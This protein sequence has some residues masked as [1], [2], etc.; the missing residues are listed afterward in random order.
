[1]LYSM[2]A[3]DFMKI[4]SWNVNG[5]RSVFK[6][7]FLGWLKANQPDIVCLQEIKADSQGLPAEYTQIKG[8]RAYFNSA[9]KKGYAGVAVYTQEK[10]LSVE[11]KLGLKR[12]DQEGRF[13]KLV[14]KN[15][16]LINFYIPHGGRAKENLKYKLEAYAKILKL[17]K[18]LAKKKTILIG[19]FNI[20]HTELDLERP[21]NNKDNIM[22]TPEERKQLDALIGLGYADTFRLRYPDKKAYTW[23]PYWGGLRARDVG[24]RIDYAFVSRPLVKKVEGAFMQKEVGGSDHCPYGVVFDL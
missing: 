9:T 24:W 19:D 21:K 22:F 8:Y 7:D 14:F 10:P 5:L 2:I 12:F 11:T 3:Y 18:P 4:V 15:F 1:M 13:L 6:K 17:V 23:W 20:A 16:I